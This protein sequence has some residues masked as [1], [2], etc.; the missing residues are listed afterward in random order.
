MFA[1]SVKSRGEPRDKGAG[2]GI[3]VWFGV[4]LLHV[5]PL[6]HLASA[7]HMKHWA[8]DNFGLNPAIMPMG[9]DNREEPS[10]DGHILG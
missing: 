1:S 4:V 5:C 6:L 3:D 8:E 9:Q 10:G 2:S 7:L